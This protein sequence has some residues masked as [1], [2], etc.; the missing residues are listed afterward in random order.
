MGHAAVSLSD[1]SPSQ[2]LLRSSAIL[3]GALCA[4]LVALAPVA[5]WLQGVDGLWTCLAACLLCLAPALGVLAVSHRF[6]GTPHALSAILAGMALRALPP[7]AVCLVLAL[8]GTGYDYIHFISYLLVF[9]LAALSIE[10]WLSV[11]LISNAQ[12]KS[13]ER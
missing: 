1:Q 9:Y 5:I 6:L 8:R 3:T 10:T 11:T 4:L 2:S 13:S 7:L 12:T